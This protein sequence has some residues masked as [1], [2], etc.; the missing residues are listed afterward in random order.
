[1]LNGYQYEWLFI[2]K[3]IEPPQ[4]SCMLSK[5]KAVGY[6]SNLVLEM[7]RSDV[8]I[9]VSEDEGF[10]LVFLE[11]ALCGLAVIARYGGGA[12]WIVEQTGCGILLDLD[13]FE[14]VAQGVVINETIHLMAREGLHH[15]GNR[16][17]VSKALK[18]ADPDRIKRNWEKF[19]EA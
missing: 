18:I 14:N 12:D 10:G 17:T 13:R 3:G 7:F 11:A 19:L 6:S 8:F 16:E 5:V 15:Y 9:L 4:W 1:M 2:G